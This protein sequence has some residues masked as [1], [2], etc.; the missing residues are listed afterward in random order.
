M[1]IN[2]NTVVRG[3]IAKPSTKDGIP[4]FSRV[5][6]QM[7]GSNGAIVGVAEGS[8]YAKLSKERCNS[9]DNLKRLFIMHDKVAYHLHQPVVGGG[10]GTSLKR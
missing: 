1:A 4:L 3:A 2:F 5:D 9:P 8:E 10:H 6:G 7:E